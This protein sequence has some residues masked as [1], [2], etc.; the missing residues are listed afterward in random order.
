MVLNGLSIFYLPNTPNLLFYVHP[1]PYWVPYILRIIYHRSSINNGIKL[2]DIL[3]ELFV[4]CGNT[5][6]G[7][8]FLWWLIWQSDT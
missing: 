6:H 1:E 2:V 3:G 7:D 4:R 8:S 5:M